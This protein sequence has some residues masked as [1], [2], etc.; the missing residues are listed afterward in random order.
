MLVET[1]YQMTISFH[2]RDEDEETDQTFD[3]LRETLDELKEME[4]ETEEEGDAASVEAQS[5]EEE[6][7]SPRELEEGDEADTDAL[8]KPDEMAMVPA[9][10]PD[11][12]TPEVRSPDLEGNFWTVSQL[13]HADQ[14]A[15]GCKSA[16]QSCDGYAA[17]TSCR[18]VV[19]PPQACVLIKLLQAGILTIVSPP[20]ILIRPPPAGILVK[21]PP[22]IRTLHSTISP[23]IWL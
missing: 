22:L 14:H 7:G 5:H 2:R 18:A 17:A 23:R 21:P 3:D 13:T 11:E 9:S 20:G 19:Y 10:H 1:L 15:R 6:S 4:E 8:R 16:F 12:R